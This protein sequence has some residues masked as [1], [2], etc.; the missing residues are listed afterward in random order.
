MYFYRYIRV[1]E[2]LAHFKFEGKS[3]LLL[4]CLTVCSGVQNIKEFNQKQVQKFFESFEIKKI[5][6]I[7][8]F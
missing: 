7:L 1:C 3:V 4:A 2:F 8:K 5:Q 6:R